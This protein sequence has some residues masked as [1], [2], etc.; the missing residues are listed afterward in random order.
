MFLIWLILFNRQHES[1]FYRRD[2]FAIDRVDALASASPLGRTATID[3]FGMISS[4]AIADA[5]EFVRVREEFGVHRTVARGSSGAYLIDPAMSAFAP[6]VASAGDVRVRVLRGPLF[7]ESFV[8]LT[9]Q[10]APVQRVARV[11]HH[12]A[13][14]VDITQ[15]VALA[16]EHANHEVVVRFNAAE[17]LARSTGHVFFSDSNGFQMQRREY[18]R[19]IPPAANLY[20]ATSEA[21]LHDA[22]NRLRLSV[23][24][25]QS[26][27]V[28]SMEA[29]MLEFVLDRRTSS[30]DNRG[31]QQALNDNLPAESSYRLLAEQ[32]PNNLPADVSSAH[33]A[34]IARELEHMVR[35]FNCKNNTKTNRSH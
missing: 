18:N 4:L 31:L 10:W 30:D 14:F 19:K 8:Q 11:Y 15:R 3:G 23:L 26:N 20:P 12:D 28:G 13:A 7:D 9:G 29:G 5:S 17:S 2:G 24:L 25:A 35:I 33:S 22:A 27:A 16:H 6:L 34:R 32:V 21:Y 1:E